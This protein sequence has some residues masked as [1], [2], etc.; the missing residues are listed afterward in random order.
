MC[1]L[2]VSAVDVPFAIRFVLVAYGYALLINLAALAVEEYSF[3]RYGR[4]RDLVAAVIASLLENVGYRQLTAWWRTMG[5]WAALRRGKQ[6]GGVMHR[7]GF[8][9]SSKP[10]TGTVASTPIRHAAPGTST[11][12][13]RTPGRHSVRAEPSRVD[14]RRE[15]AR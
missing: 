6:V 14:A 7:S 2:V 11:S 1:G 4:W 13:N 12:D 10:S 9:D 5:A 8:G 3:R 15:A